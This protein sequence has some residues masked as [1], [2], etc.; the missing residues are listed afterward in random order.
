MA[1]GQRTAR[2]ASSTPRRTLTTGARLCRTVPL[3]QLLTDAP[4][5]VTIGDAHSDL[6]GL[7]RTLE[8]LELV[9]ATG[10]RCDGGR[11]RLISVGDLIDGRDENDLA[12]LE[13]GAEVFDRIVCGNHEAALMGG[14]TFK[15]LFLPD[16]EVGQLLNRLARS[17]QLTV[18]ETAGETL[19]THAGVSDEW[20]DN[21]HADDIR[22]Q[23]EDSWFAFLDNREDQD[24]RLFAIDAHRSRNGG[25]YGGALWGDWRNLVAGRRPSFSQIVGHS[26]VGRP[27]ESMD[28]AV[29]C[30]DVEGDTIAAAATDA[31]GATRVGLDLP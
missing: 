21:A 25:A 1:R 17:E 9:D 15:G 13:Y 8:R 3:N 28:G 24:G 20:F 11:H 6:P 16:P 30:I 22:E 5:T 26:A 4:A 27:E 31:E 2:T 18:A 23:L 10:R 19:I 7:R 12:T 14:P 29:V